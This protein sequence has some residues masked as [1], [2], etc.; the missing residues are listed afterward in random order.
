MLVRAT[1]KFNDYI[2][3]LLPKLDMKKTVFIYSMWSEYVNPASKH[4]NKKY[5]DLLNKF[6]CVKHVHTSGHASVE[7]LASVCNL[8]NPSLGIIPIHSDNSSYYQNLPIRE[9]LKEKIITESR[10]FEGIN[11]KII[12]S[13]GNIDQ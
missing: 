2:E 11:I 5:I 7:C 8:A 1:D 9:E 10:D 6:S 4:A 13:A 3:Y 12:G